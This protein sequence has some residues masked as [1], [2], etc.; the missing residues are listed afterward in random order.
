MTHYFDASALVKL[1]VEEPETAALRA[2]LLAEP[3]TV[4]SCDLARTELFRTVR[5]VS[6]ELLTDA[7]RLLSTITLLTIETTDFG[8]AG[9]LNP[10]SLRTLD[11]IHVV[12]AL[13]LGDDLKGM[14]T[15]DKRL[16]DACTFVDIE[17]IAPQ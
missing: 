8:D 12:A 3:R 17:T 5:R 1:V 4:V 11:A 14:V 15:Y 10:V 6:P 9:R 7:E 16:V 2:W 13:K